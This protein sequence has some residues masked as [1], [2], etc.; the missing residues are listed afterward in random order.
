LVASAHNRRGVADCG[1]AATLYQQIAQRYSSRM[2]SLIF[3]LACVVTLAASGPSYSAPSCSPG[4]NSQLCEIAAA[5]LSDNP[6]FAEMQAGGAEAETA[7]VSRH[8]ERRRSV[9]EILNQLSEPTWRDLYRAGYVIA[10]GD[11]A[12]EDMLAHAIAIRALSLAPNEADARFLVA[13]T[14]DEI[15]RRY[16]GL[17]LYGRQ[18]YFELNP[19]TGAPTLA[20]LPQM[21][22]PPLPDAIGLQFHRVDGY[23]RCAPGVGVPS[24]PQ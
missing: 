17:Q 16:V 14:I 19:T 8:A 4:D 11:T 20:C 22:D 18:K 6:T 24:R 13:M 21:I 3:G 9:R 10:Y 23:E 12:E 5:T 2:K 15:G 1:H 7:R